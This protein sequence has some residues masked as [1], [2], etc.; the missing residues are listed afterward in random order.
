MKS[1]LILIGFIPTLLCA[2]G[3]NLKTQETKL[4]ISVGC[5][6]IDYLKVSQTGSEYLY[7][8]DLGVVTSPDYKNDESTAVAGCY[9]LLRANGFIDSNDEI[10]D[11]TTFLSVFTVDKQGLSL[12]K[13]RILYC[14]FGN[15]NPKNPTHERLLPIYKW[16]SIPTPTR[17]SSDGKE[18]K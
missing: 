15:Q 3:T 17:F 4:T 1:L 6:E 2:Q 9:G 5:K 16:T 13:A 11:K 14:L 7:R 12:D 18:Y 10:K 8:T